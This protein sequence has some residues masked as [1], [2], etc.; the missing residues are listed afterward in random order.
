MCFLYPNLQSLTEIWRANAVEVWCIEFRGD[1]YWNWWVFMKHPTK[2]SKKITVKF[3]NPNRQ[4][5]Q[6]PHHLSKFQ[7]NSI[8]N[9]KVEKK[10]QFLIKRKRFME[11]NQLQ[12]N[13]RNR[14]KIKQ[15]IAKF[16]TLN[17]RKL[18]N[19]CKEKNLQ[20]KIWLNQGSYYRQK[21]LK[22]KENEREFHSNPSFL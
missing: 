1:G 9:G 4:F 19:E 12:K 20:K 15:K 22:E 14:K 18:C 17:N 5:Q 8:L 13:T 7:N 6:F 3:R 2:P 10:I 21:L 16:P 11:N